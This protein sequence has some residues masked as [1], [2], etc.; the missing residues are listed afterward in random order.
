MDN[1]N[2]K[3][4]KAERIVDEFLK[5]EEVRNSNLSTLLLVM[6]LLSASIM[7]ELDNI[8]ASNGLSVTFEDYLN[9]L[10]EFN[11]SVNNQS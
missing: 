4:D 3:Y 11:D 6:C 5:L 7:K 9:L 2:V 8:N 1:Y 10:S